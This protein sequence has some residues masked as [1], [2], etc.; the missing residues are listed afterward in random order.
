MP[1]LRIACATDEAYAPWCAAM[2]QALVQRHPGALRVHLLHTDSLGSATRDRL[3]QLVEGGGARWQALPVDAAAVADLPRMDRIPPIMWLRVLLPALLPD[4]SRVLYLDVDTLAL[5][6]LLPLWHAP[7]GDALVGAVDNVL[8][9]ATAD[10]PAQLG[11]LPP[12]RYFNSGVLLFNLEAMRRDGSAQQI[13]DCARRRAGELAWPD[14]DALNLVLGA[15]RAALHPRWNAQNSLFY[16]PERSREVLGAAR[17][18]AVAVPALL[19]FEGPAWAKPWHCLNDHPCRGAWRAAQRAS[20]WALPDP[21]SPL[22]R[23]LYHLPRPLTGAL[24]SALGYP[25]PAV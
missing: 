9:P 10:R 19:H 17:D 15:R 18:E 23:A 16:W 6:S 8:H 14:Q 21:G 7:L 4:A 25:R 3:R 1:E 24:R 5:Q 12:A 22:R 11:L 13:L 20:G 2:L